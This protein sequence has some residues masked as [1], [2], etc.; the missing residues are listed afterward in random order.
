[1]LICTPI[2]LKS[3]KAVIKQMQLL[4]NKVDIAEIWLDHIEDLNLETL[5]KNKPLPILCVCKKLIDQGRFRGSYAEEADILIKAIKHGADYIDIPLKMPKQLCEKIIKG[6]RKQEA[7]SRSK[8]IFSYHHFKK[9]PPIK[10]LR[11]KADEM[12]KRGADIVKL[13]VM[14]KTLKD[15]V[16]MIFL[17]KELQKKGIDHILITMGKEGV[18]TRLITP[19]LGGTMMFAPLKKTATTAPGQLTVK[20]LKQLWGEFDHSA[21][22]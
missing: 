9:T 18:L 10:E 6:S 15:C 1:M 11:K 4:A 7:G 17:A 19:Q 20:E 21:N 3:Q 5:L 12:V 8:I 14:G 22:L 16:E 13:A 2:Q